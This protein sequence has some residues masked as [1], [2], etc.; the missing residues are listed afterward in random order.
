MLS[1]LEIILQE[2][3]H[4]PTTKIRNMPRFLSIIPLPWMKVSFF[5]TKALSM[6]FRSHYA[7]FLKDCTL[8]HLL[9][10]LYHPF[11][12]LPGSSPLASK[13]DPRIPHSIHHQLLPISHLLFFAI[14]LY[15][16]T[17]SLQYFGHLMRRVD[18][19]E[20]TLMLGGIWGRRRRGRPR[21]ASRTRWK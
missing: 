16:Y 19:L 2:H 3:P 15:M 1:I 7:H 20:K 4:T 18:S 13:C 8:G 21:M 9:C 17:V 10:L 11:C 5:L 14:P 12:F 6:S